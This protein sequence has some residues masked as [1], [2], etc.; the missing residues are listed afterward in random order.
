MKSVIQNSIFQALIGVL[1]LAIIGFLMTFG[2]EKTMDIFFLDETAYL[3]RG[4]KMFDKIPKRWGPLYCT[5]YKGL[6]LIEGN[7]IQLF[8]LNFKLMAVLPVLLFFLVLRK[9]SASTVFSFFLSACFLISSYNLPVDPKVS[10]FCV[11]IILATLWFSATAKQP[12]YKW[13]SFLSGTLLLSFARPEFY[14]AFLLILI[15]GV[16]YFSWN[17]AKLTKQGMFTFGAFI[18]IAFVLHA[19]LGNPLMVKLGGNNRSLIAFGEHFAYNF[20]QWNH[21]E[22]YAWLAWEETVQAQFGPIH[23]VTDAIQSNF[24]MFWKHIT[25]NL[26]NFFTAFFGLLVHM[27]IPLGIGVVATYIVGAALSIY[28]IY[29]LISQR[30]KVPIELWYLLLLAIPTLISCVLVYPRNHYLV[31]LVPVVGLLFVSAFNFIKDDDRITIPVILIIGVCF[32]FLGPNADDFKFFEIRKEE[33]VLNNIRAIE[34][35]EQVK[36][37][38]SIKVLSNEGDFSA[39]V[40]ADLVWVSAID[41]RRDSFD[42]FLKTNNPDVIYITETMLKNPY[43]FEDENWQTFLV[44]FEDFEYVK[45]PLAPEMKEYF[46]VKNNLVN[47]F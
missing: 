45:V 13:L 3:V 35:L 12:F 40:K 32:I 14:M 21:S 1:L 19:G 30:K 23:S 41:K 11:M 42:A 44:D 39:F 15:G 43:Y 34:M 47:Y 18:V 7:L 26:V 29:Y 28:F 8:Y 16:I 10:F 22:L 17:R 46:L 2:L 25:F 36:S 27:I 20:A 9:F 37:A 5:W 4:T 24:A 31:L 33:G 38:D 6:S